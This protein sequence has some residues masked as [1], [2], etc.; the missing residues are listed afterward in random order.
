[1]VLYIAIKNKKKSKKKYFYI[2]ITF[3]KQNLPL[4]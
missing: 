4:D 3:K 2:K 1:M